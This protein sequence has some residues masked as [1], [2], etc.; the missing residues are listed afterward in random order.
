[1]TRPETL[2]SRLCG[3]IVGLP[4]LFHENLEIN[5][6]GM[7]AHVDFLIENGI[8]VLLVSLGIS[9]YPYLMEEEVRQVTRTVV[10]AA[11]GRATVIVSTG[12]WWTGGSVDFARYAQSVG[13]DGLLVVAPFH[14]YHPRYDPAIHNEA[15]Y[16]HFA[17]VAEAVDIGVLIHEKALP[18]YSGAKAPF[19]LS[20]I[21]RL[22]EIDNVVGMK[23]EGGDF[24]YQIE[25]LTAVGD[26]I[27]VIDDS[28]KV[29]FLYTYPLGSPAYVSGI[30]QFAPQSSIRFWNHLT[31]GELEQ[32]RQMIARVEIPYS[33]KIVE[34]GWV[35]AIK[36]AMEFRGL[37]GGPMRAPGVG[38]FPQQKEAFRQFLQQLGLLE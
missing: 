34:L 29:S 14:P 3:P 21:R 38:L 19:S 23:E 28:G 16:R 31:R 6:A 35:G 2:R 1:M 24:N 18:G 32:A 9:E 11:A 37:P 17:A 33:T 20:L 26:R 8:R 25:I 22:A 4:T 12:L 30:G 36:A 27:A 13:V 15:L 7:K 5:H 10:E